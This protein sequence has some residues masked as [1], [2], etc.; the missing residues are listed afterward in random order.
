MR[1]ETVCPVGMENARSV[2][3]AADRACSDHCRARVGGWCVTIS[4]RS[5]FMNGLLTLEVSIDPSG[6]DR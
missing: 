3:V 5:G 6:Q 1:G 2:A 4:P